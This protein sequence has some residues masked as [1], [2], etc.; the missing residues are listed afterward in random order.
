MKEIRPKKYETLKDEFGSK[1]ADKYLLLCKKIE[2]MFTG[3]VSYQVT[4]EAHQYS[5]TIATGK[6]FKEREV[7]RKGNLDWN[8][9]N[10]LM[11]E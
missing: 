1:V 2:P 9:I 11:V 4:E 8:K 7:E 3:P 6:T 5:L 10:K